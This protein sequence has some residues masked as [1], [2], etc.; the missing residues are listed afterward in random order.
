MK[1]DNYAR[2]VAADMSIIH[3]KWAIGFVAV[4]LAV[5][6]FVRLFNGEA[7]TNT[8]VGRLILRLLRGEDL[9]DLQS[10]QS[11]F[12]AFIHH[13]SKIFMLVCGITSVSFLTFYVKQGV[14]R[15]DYFHG[16]AA[17]SA[18]LALFIPA[19]SGVVFAAEQLIFPP[20]IPPE[21]FRIADWSVQ[22]L[23]ILLYYAGGWLIGA[24]FYRSAPWGFAFIALSIVLAFGSETVWEAVQDGSWSLTVP[25][26]LAT[27]V[28][29][30]GLTFWIVRLTTRRIRIKL[31]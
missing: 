18:A 9:E 27:Y 25:I 31:K 15:R 2:N 7:E 20:D 8:L 26:S 28:L 5:Y 13:P 3:G 21:P 22:C 16:A 14:T 11:G 4:V 1:S 30:I 12:L 6:I 17:S 24:G 23:S 10:G 29:A 19:V